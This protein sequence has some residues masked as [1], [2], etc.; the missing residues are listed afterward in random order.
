MHSPTFTERNIQ[1]NKEDK[2][3]LA[4]GPGQATA[5]ITIELLCVRGLAHLVR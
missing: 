3:L 4:Q 5:R 2:G 1:S